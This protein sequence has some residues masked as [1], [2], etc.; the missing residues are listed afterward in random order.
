L[1]ASFDLLALCAAPEIINRELWIPVYPCVVLPD[2][3]SGRG[4]L[5]VSSTFQNAVK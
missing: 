1:T 4:A 3:D 5:G 2:G